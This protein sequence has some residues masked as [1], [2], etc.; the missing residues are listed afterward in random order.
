MDCMTDHINQLQKARD[1]LVAK[2]REM[3]EAIATTASLSPDRASEFA[4]MQ[5]AINAV[6]EAIRDEAKQRDQGNA[7]GSGFLSR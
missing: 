6:D 2:R 1:R 3:A 4:T 5:E 7:S